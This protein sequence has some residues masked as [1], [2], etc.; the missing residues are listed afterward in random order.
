MIFAVQGNAQVVGAEQK[1]KL[2]GRGEAGETS[3]QICNIHPT[4]FKCIEFLMHFIVELGAGQEAGGGAAG[5]VEQAGGRAGEAQVSSPRFHLISPYP[6]RGWKK[7]RCIV[8][9]CRL[10]KLGKVSVHITG[11][12]RGVLGKEYGI[13]WE[14]YSQ[15]ADPPLLGKILK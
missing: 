1:R 4:P 9:F 15:I 8:K 6:R 5:E 12:V 7:F 3:L 11:Q 2:C 14:L 13:I 10:G